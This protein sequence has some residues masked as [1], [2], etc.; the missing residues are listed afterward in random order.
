MSVGFARSE[1]LKHG[2]RYSGDNRVVPGEV[3]DVSLL[4]TEGEWSIV[5]FTVSA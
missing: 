5:M 4:P 3:H 2:T 1:S